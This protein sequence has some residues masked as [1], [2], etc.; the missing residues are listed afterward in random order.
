MGL[1]I[2]DKKVIDATIKETQPTFLGGMI[3]LHQTWKGV[4]QCEHEMSNRH[5]PGDYA[6][7][8][9]KELHFKRIT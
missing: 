2:S 6:A 1:G 3:D 7:K 5:L 4:D 9:N 8:K